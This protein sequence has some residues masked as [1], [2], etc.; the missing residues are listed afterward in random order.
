MPARDKRD[1]TEP[2]FSGEAHTD[3][4]PIEKAGI[5]PAFS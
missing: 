2:D 3:Y 4:I 5:R 1:G